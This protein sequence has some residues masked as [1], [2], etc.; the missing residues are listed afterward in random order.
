MLS[1]TPFKESGTCAPPAAAVLELRSKD[2]MKRDPCSATATTLGQESYK[3]NTAWTTKIG[4]HKTDLNY[5]KVAS[6]NTSCLKAHA[7]I[8]RLLM[9]GF[10][11]AY[12][13]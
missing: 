11:D 10:F 7:G 8:Y 2:A 13:L 5:G 9:K 6:F 12:A 3:S 1:W 4:I